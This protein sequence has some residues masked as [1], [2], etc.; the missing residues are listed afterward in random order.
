V[1]SCPALDVNYLSVRGWLQPG[2][3]S[4]CPLAIGN[5]PNSEVI[6]LDMHAEAEWLSLSWRP[7]NTNSSNRDSSGG[8]SS[9][10]SLGGWESA[11]GIIIPI[12]RVPSGFIDNRAYFICSG[13]VI[14]GENA[15]ESVG[16][17]A[18]C[19]RRVTKLYLSQPIYGQSRFLCRHC[20]RLV[21]VGNYEKQPWLRASRRA[22]KLRHR[23]GITGLYV[24]EKPYGMWVPEYERLLEEVLQAEIQATEAGTA[25]L[26]R[27]VAWIDRRRK[28]QFTL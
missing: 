25:R 12:A 17:V 11:V 24:P 10:K 7:V 23:L 3:S 2:E 18:G 15:G 4:C 5:G 9:G 16:G 20:C 27:L 14:A 1:D 6:L 8:S 22:N 13:A 19:G 28:L 26:L 21:Y